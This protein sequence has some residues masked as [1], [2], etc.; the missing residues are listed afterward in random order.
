MIT[1]QHALFTHNSDGLDQGIDA[2]EGLDTPNKQQHTVVY[3]NT[4]KFFGLIGWN[5]IKVAG[6]HP[7]RNHADP[8]CIGLVQPF[9]LSQLCHS[10]SHNPV[11]Q[12]ENFIFTPDAVIPFGFFLAAGYAP[13]HLPQGMK[14]V[15]NR[16]V[17]GSL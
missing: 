6:I 3:R 4:D 11:S 17:P 14:H 15:N 10:G 12:F 9:Q 5:R 13:F 16:H 8:L 2:F 7:R 1:I